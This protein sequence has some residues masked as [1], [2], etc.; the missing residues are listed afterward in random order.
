LVSVPV[1][2]ASRVFPGITVFWHHGGLPRASRG[3]GGVWRRGGSRNP[4]V[5]FLPPRLACPPPWRDPTPV[6]GGAARTGR[7]ANALVYPVVAAGCGVANGGGTVS[8]RGNGVA[9]G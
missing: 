3:R 1:S 4:S 2:P 6:D 7:S 9:A 5:A 8:R